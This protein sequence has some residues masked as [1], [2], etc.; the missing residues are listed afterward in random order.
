MSDFEALCVQQN[1]KQIEQW[2]KTT[3]KGSLGGSAL[4]LTAIEQNAPLEIL[5]QLGHKGCK[6]NDNEI[7]V[8]FCFNLL[9]E[10]DSFS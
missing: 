10:Y 5:K 9:N 6:L 3:T 7:N 8:R 1:W 4:L 2:L